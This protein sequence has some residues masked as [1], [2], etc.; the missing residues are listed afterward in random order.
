MASRNGF[1]VISLKFIFNRCGRAEWSKQELVRGEL[2]KYLKMYASNTSLKYCCALLEEGNF[3]VDVD[4]SKEVSLVTVF[5]ILNKMY[6]GTGNML[7]IE[8]KEIKKIVTVG[9]SC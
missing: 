5:N 7:S 1:E 8:Y 9:I 4:F 2:K 3:V 6:A